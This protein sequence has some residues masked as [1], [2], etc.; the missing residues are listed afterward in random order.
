M[1]KTLSLIA[2]VLAGTLV[3]AQ[4]EEGEEPTGEEIVVSNHGAD[5]SDLA[6]ATESG[7]EKGGI[8]SS[9][10]RAK[11]LMHANANAN[12]NRTE[13][14]GNAA[15]QGKPEELPTTTNGKPEMLPPVTPPTQ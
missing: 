5:I 15:E 12:F 2:F 10:A 9:A 1:K 11:A 7:K 14:P 13:L 6:K 4:G 8:I 3:F